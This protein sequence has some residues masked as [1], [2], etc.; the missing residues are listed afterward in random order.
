MKMNR[1]Q[2]IG[3]AGAVSAASLLAACN[4]G[5][6]DDASGSKKPYIAIVSK[7]FSQEYWQAV[8]KGA[9]KQAKKSGARITFVGPDTESDVEQQVTMLTNALAKK[10]D[11][12]GFAALDSKAAAPLMQQAKNDKI[13]VIAFDS[14]V[15]SD[16]PV[17]T[18]A[19]D[20]KAAAAADAKHLA[21]LIGN[22][23]TIGLVIHDQTSKSGV[24]RR[25]GFMDWMKKNAPDVK[26]LTPQYT[27]SDLRKAANITK[28]IIA[29]NHDLA[30][31]YGSNEASA[32]GVAK[33]ITESGKKG[34]KAVGFDSGQAQIDAIK[35]GVLAGSIT[36][37]PQKM[38]ALVVSS[39]LKAIKGKDLPKF[40]DT[41]FY[42]YD[43]KNINDAKI[44]ACLYH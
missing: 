27:N 34:L 1:R 36:Q 25:D 26:M 8:K 11:A 7:G 17:T 18:A 31:I 28:S 12:L 30:G 19:T 16:V 32:E 21:K 33:G 43:K 9:E 35:K 38:G 20:N 15:D 42:W 44:Q 2:L 40:V 3:A 5:G 41:G 39:A 24:D 13:P 37:D 23:G 22:K 6:S 4:R 29:S 10:P 14:G